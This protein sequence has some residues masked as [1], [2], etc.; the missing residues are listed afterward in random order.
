M[1]YIKQYEIKIMPFEAQKEIVNASSN[2]DDVKLNKLIKKYKGESIDFNYNKGY[3]PLLYAAMFD[4][5]KTTK[6]LIDNGA[7]INKKSDNCET[8]L[9]LA[10]KRN[11]R[12]VLELLL[13]SGADWFIK[14]DNKY[15]PIYFDNTFIEYIPTKGTE[16]WIAGKYPEQYKEYLIRKES[17]KYNL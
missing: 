15:D 13:N 6:I 16:K 17:D 9:M 14:N 5:E 2:N 10:A 3:T 11:N 7:D 8:P 4:C 1:K 12:K